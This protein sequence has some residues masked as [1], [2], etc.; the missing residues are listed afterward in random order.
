[1]R[2]RE[3]GSGTGR[4]VGR[5]LDAPARLLALALLVC[6]A[7]AGPPAAGAGVVR[8]GGGAA[9]GPGAAE[10]LE[11]GEPP[12]AGRVT[13]ADGLEDAPGSAGAGDVEKIVVVAR[14]LPSVEKPALEMGPQDFLLRPHATTKEIFNN[15]PGLLVVQHAGGGK[16]LQ[17]FLRGFDIDHGT[18]LLLLA[19]GVP[20]NI[21]SHAHGQGYADANFLIPEAIDGVQL[22][23]G[24]YRADLG[25]FAVAGAVSFHSKEEFERD[26]VKAEGG[27]F[28][29]ARVVV[30]ASPR[31]SWGRTLV[32]AEA[33]HTNGPVDDPQNF[34][35]G[36][37]LAKLTLGSE[38]W[39]KLSASLRAYAADWDASGQIPLRAVE[40]REIGR[41]GAIDPTEGGATDR[42][43]ANLR[44]DAALV[45]D[46][47]LALQA[48][49]QR[50]SFRLFSDFT[51][52]RD[53]GLRFVATPGGGV[54]DTCRGWSPSHPVCDPVPAGAA[55][56][57][58]DGIEQRDRR[59]SFGARATYERPLAEAALPAALR[60]GLSIQTDLARVSLHRQVR[61]ERFFAVNAVAVREH[62]FGPFVEATVNLAD[63]ARLELG[64]RGDLFLF[65]VADRLSE[66][67][68]DRNFVAVRIRGREFD[69]IA[70][71]KLRVVVS[72]PGLATDLFL[73]AG[74]GFHSN[75]ARAVVRTGRDGLVRAVSGEAGFRGAWRP[76]LDVSGSVWILDLDSELV[77]SG[78]G[79]DV[80]GGRDPVTGNFVPA[81]ASR[82]WGVDLSGRY[83]P[84][85]WLSLDLDLAWAD[86]RFRDGGAIPL[87]PTFLANGGVTL[88]YRG[89]T[90]A[91]RARHLDDRPANEDR[92]ITAEGWTLLDLVLRYRWRNAEASLALLNLTDASWREAQFAEATCLRGEVGRDAA[93]PSDGSLPPQGVAAS[94][95]EGLTFTPGAPLSVRGGIRIWF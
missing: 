2:R 47:H 58:G 65:D 17:Y 33:F 41:F 3:G 55:V 6:P 56:V 93:C 39:R 23:K 11:A 21:R 19:D 38:P 73:L 85:D 35:R 34:W 80:D 78:D 71:P 83:R 4:A 92:S 82:R 24:P 88:D 87:A 48:W 40:R 49:A 18:D 54:V 42:Q 64:L 5:V 43:I 90:A 8:A 15:L 28:D 36:S 14:R 9:G 31:L 53:T 77:F 12:V 69:A 89:F 10:I 61:R 13:G 16:A 59:W 84:T 66:Q 60:V 81:G 91:L 79:G 72:P 94:G 57:P 70:S 45:D 37:A 50:Y 95:I 30:G 75:D 27:S 26:F 22:F 29:T 44:Y 20:I 52:Y 25:D 76:D 74:S 32:A 62:S 46:A 68:P 63:W 1:M 7:W 51:L 67:R 86:P